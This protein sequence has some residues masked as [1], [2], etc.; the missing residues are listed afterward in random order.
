MQNDGCDSEFDLLSRMEGDGGNNDEMDINVGPPA[1]G[2]MFTNNSCSPAPTI[3]A[4]IGMNDEY[5]Q[6]SDTLAWEFEANNSSNS[7]IGNNNVN[8][9]TTLQMEQQINAF[10]ACQQPQQPNQFLL[11]SR[12][13]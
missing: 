10:A 11:P 9:L 12:Q 2:Q 8:P 3:G 1:S 7:N 4:A 5:Q 6:L 13:M